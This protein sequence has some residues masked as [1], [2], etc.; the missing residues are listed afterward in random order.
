MK[1]ILYSETETAFDT[2]GI[3]IL[4]DAK[5]AQVV[6]ELN[7]V[8]E[9]TLKYPDTGI[10]AASI[11]DRCIILTKPDP[12]AEPQPF[13]IYRINPV[14]KGIITAYA[15]HIAYDTRGIPVAPFEAAS[16]TD[17]LTTM[18]ANAV[19]ACPF[20]FTT[21]KSTAGKITT[22]VP[23]S[24][25]TV[26]GNAEGSILDAYGGE[27]EFNRFNIHLHS[28]RGADRGVS[29]RYGKN[30]KTLEQDRNCAECYTGVYPYWQSSE[31][32]LVQL[33]DKVIHASGAFNYTR[34]MPLD[35]SLEWD[36]APTEGQLRERAEK[37]MTD[38]KIGVPKVSWKIQFVQ[39]EQTE[40]YKDLALLERVL[41][42][43]TVSVIFPR[44]N[45]NASA[46]VIKIDFDSLLERYNS[47][48]LGSV[49]SNLADTI[50]KQQKEIEKKPEA[51]MVQSMIVTLT[52]TILGARGG[53]VRLLDTDGDG[54]Q[55]TLYIGD[56]A[57][58]AQ[59]TKVWR[60]NYEGW[61]VSKTG[62][63]GPFIM[64]ATLEDGLLAAS[65]TAANL[66]AGTIKSK[67]GK[68]F[69]CDLDKGILRMQATE[70]S[71]SGK[72]VEQIA[73]EKVN[74]Y[75]AVVAKNFEELQSQI[76]GNITSWFGDVVPTASNE[77]AV[78]W[79]TEELK[80]QHLGDLYYINEGVEHGGT[81]YRW[82]QVNGTYKW[83]I[84]EDTDVAKALAAAAQ[85]Q[86]TADSKRRVFVVQP[87]TPYDV[88][89]LWTQGSGGD[90]MR[91]KTS[92]A[93]GNY[94]ASDWELASKYIDATVAQSK[95]DEAQSNAVNA[96]AADATNKANTALRDAKSYADSAAKSAVDAQT[97]L[98]IFNKLTNNGTAQGVFIKDGQLF[99]NASYLATGI[100]TSADGSV[101]IDL[102][103][104][105]VEILLPETSAPG[106]WPKKLELSRRGFMGY[107]WN[108]DS[109]EYVLSL[110]M[111]PGS[112]GDNA[113]NW[114]TI[115]SGNASIGIY[116]SGTGKKVQ[117]GIR[118]NATN[119]RGNDISIGEAL[120]SDV[121]ID[122]DVVI[123]GEQY[124][125]VIIKPG[126]TKIWS[127]YCAVGGS[128]TV[129]NTADYDLFAIKLGTSSETYDTIVLG[130]KSGNVIHGVGG[131]AGSSEWYKRL[132]YVTITFSGTTWTLVDACRHS[133]T[134]EGVI[135]VSE[136]LSI[137]E[138]RGVI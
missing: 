14:S 98:D 64:G 115:S 47:V 18:K 97:Q 85:A 9:L 5:S 69:F 75:A 106:G 101:Q 1:P 46:R 113:S 122:G 24:M 88:G 120:Y 42:G 33:P 12:V 121:A 4:N 19:V 110:S 138:I 52:A 41:L 30:L 73:E 128:I 15:R 86:D 29:V 53:A 130:Y 66:V 28:R 6:Q 74:D 43:D 63:N 27:Y 131:F 77:P 37:Y 109:G 45:I 82:A 95:A 84:V 79:N 80:N 134:T 26:L 108:L 123:G 127:G 124:S 55:D 60:F 81:A 40:E 62:Y 94:S 114:T 2:N 137:K 23:K 32:Q 135:G 17:A 44:M 93:S 78:N 39:L 50:V 49:K 116:P 89:D 13:R 34:V 8:Y 25:W 35:L 61:A 57:D 51:S 92:R 99:I 76:D 100:I 21:D 133:I 126:K 7:G 38:N 54:L 129:S 91:C 103:N 112:I 102:L 68:T 65:V 119:V 132:Y 56:K 117:I 36:T 58:P 70:F 22:A 48:T 16:V 67:D 136:T 87:V 3:G 90:L 105:K 10:H 118:G 59:A 11:T 96:A 71:V 107:G 125:N 72:T 20:N 111:S 83:V 31:G 104:N